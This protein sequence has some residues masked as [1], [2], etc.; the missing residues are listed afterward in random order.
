MIHKTRSRYI[1]PLTFVIEL[2]AFRAA[3]LENSLFNQSFIKR[4]KCKK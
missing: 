2:I 1:T 4:R 3:M